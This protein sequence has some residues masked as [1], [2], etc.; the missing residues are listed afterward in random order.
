MLVKRYLTPSDFSTEE[1]WRLVDWCMRQ[2]A[3]EFTIDCLGSDA[4]AMAKTW[5]R[6]RKMVEPFARGEKVRERMSGPTADELTR[7]T[8][9]W[10]LCVGS[11]GALRHVL[12]A[13]LMQYEPREDG[14]F[15]NPVL[16]RD[17]ELI[18]GVLSHEAFAVLRVSELEAGELA[19]AGFITHDSLPRIG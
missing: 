1:T 18:L 9:L 19:S 16:Y 13:G 5:R 12:S 11:L 6:F 15:E 10:E 4:D 8:E 14:W 3:D 17:G 7:P 2:G